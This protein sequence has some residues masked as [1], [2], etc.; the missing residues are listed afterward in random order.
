MIIFA[1]DQWNSALAVNYPAR[2]F[3]IK[4]GDSFENIREKSNGECIA[5]H[6]PVTTIASLSP[7]K[8]HCKPNDNF[9]VDCEDDGRER[10][11]LY[12]ENEVKCSK[13]DIRKA[14]H[15]ECKKSDPDGG[16]RFGS[17]K[18]QFAHDGNDQ[19]GNA[20]G[21]DDD[22]D[23]YNNEENLGDIEDENQ[24]DSDN[25]KSS[26]AAYEKEF[27]QPDHVREEMFK[28]ERNKMRSPKEG[29]ACLDR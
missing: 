18:E 25:F 2:K 3:G 7:Q 28:K 22:T 9:G 24:G 11:G 4:R 10:T 16:G 26:K 19:G 23:N 15:D 17:P 5:I 1:F 21:N 20:D 12:E 27:N 13:D 29:K 14:E 6:L 8:M